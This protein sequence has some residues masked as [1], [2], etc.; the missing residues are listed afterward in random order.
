M[1]STDPRAERNRTRILNVARAALAG[2]GEVSLHTIA[3]RAG[4]GQGTLY[5]RFPTREALV[6]AVYRQDMRELVE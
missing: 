3:K 4:V 6:L 5:R 2:S 1:A